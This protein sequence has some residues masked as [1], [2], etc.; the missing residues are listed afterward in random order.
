[1]LVEACYAIN[2]GTGQRELYQLP[3]EPSGSKALLL[4]GAG[5]GNLAVKL[6]ASKTFI[7]VL[8]F[9]KQ[10]NNLTYY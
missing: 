8:L 4:T 6:S 5:G 7:E 2:L 3:V 9:I 1:M 10:D